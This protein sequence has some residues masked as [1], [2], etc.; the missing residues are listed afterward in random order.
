LCACCAA[1][2]TSGSCLRRMFRAMQCRL[3][4]WGLR[5]RGTNGSFFRA[6]HA[7]PSCCTCHARACRGHPRLLM[8][9]HQD[10]DGRNKSGHDV[11]FFRS[12]PR[13][14][15]PAQYMRG[16]SCGAGSPRSRG[17]T[18][19]FFCHTHRTLRRHARACRGHPR[20]LTG[21]IKT[22]MAGT[23]PA[24]TLHFSVHPR[25]SGDPGK[26]NITRN[27]A[28]CPLSERFLNTQISRTDA[29]I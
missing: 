14:R 7:Q 21:F 24:M 28:E 1:F 25:E 26:V 6:P 29:R 5:V 18:D 13:K 8:G 9:F 22:W 20:L 19:Y 11:A 15:D 16:T 27:I 12:V 2:E 10:V 23:S 4:L 17:R 3:W